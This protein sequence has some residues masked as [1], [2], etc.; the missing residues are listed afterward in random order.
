[1]GSHM[2]IFIP[3]ITPTIWKEVITFT[4]KKLQVTIE[5]YDNLELT[6]EWLT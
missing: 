1:M 2:Q 6:D 5:N 3:E 4:N